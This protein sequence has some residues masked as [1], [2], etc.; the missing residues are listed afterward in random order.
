M[1]N[2]RVTKIIP[3]KDV[4]SLYKKTKVTEEDLKTLLKKFNLENALASLGDVSSTI[5]HSNDDN[6]VGKSGY[7]DPKTRIILS[8]HALAY[9]ANIFLVSK[10]GDYKERFLSDNPQNILVLCNICHNIL[11]D[12]LV[13]KIKLDQA[14]DD[15][16]NSWLVR[17]TFE[18]LTLQ[19]KLNYL[20]ARSIFL[21]RDLFKEF[22]SDKLGSLDQIFYEETSLS[23]EEY[24][25]IATIIAAMLPETVYVNTATYTSANIPNLRVGMTGE[26]L[27]NFLNILSIDYSGFIH[28]DEL[29]NKG[30]DS[31]YTKTR[32]NP[33]FNYPIIKTT[34][35]TLGKMYV[36]PNTPIFIHKS[37]Y[38]LFWWFH[39]YFE[40]RGKA[41]DFR[42]YFGK[43]FEKYVGQILQGIYGEKNVLKGFAYGSNKA[44]GEFSDW[45]VI[46]KNYV[47]LFEAKASQLS[48]E[49]KQTGNIEKIA[50]DEAKKIIK[51][52]LQLFKIVQDI[53]N[54]EKL[55]QY[56]EKEV[57]PVIVVYDIPSPALSI[58]N[59]LIKERLPQIEKAENLPGLSD[60]QYYLVNIEDLELFD[61][62]T[63]LIELRDVITESAFDAGYE[64]ILRNTK[65]SALGNRF[66]DEI[67]N[68]YFSCF[69][70][71][72]KEA[73]ACF[74]RT[75]R[76]EEITF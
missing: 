26:K 60:F 15:D 20:I 58:V 42:N 70:E 33:L 8:Q 54:Y 59:N 32:F 21:F 24:L 63:D 56:Q 7:R 41:L 39:R 72:A 17:M 76:E 29:R 28:E 75:L 14:D 6:C 51:G 10:A 45:I 74:E 65:G 67:L 18:Q 49:S 46:T 64:D 40:K 3:D 68:E 5:F 43:V 12:P 9:L 22:P 4:Y 71:D 57:V 16:R 69:F 30:L 52:I 48:L 2:Q 35:N 37:Y 61:D 19:F 44:V 23:I 47:Y 34:R 13:E 36:I 55:K 11:V 1:E 53:P 25:R 73:K 38:G 62:C 31:K 66:L 50:E 27:I